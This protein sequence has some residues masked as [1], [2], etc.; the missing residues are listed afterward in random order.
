MKTI[1]IYLSFQFILLVKLLFAQAPLPS[2]QLVANQR[3]H[4]FGEI[5]EANGKVSHTFVFT[6]TSD[7]IAFISRIHSGCG[8]IAAEYTREPIRPKKTGTVT[9]SYNPA[10]HPGFFSKEVVVL[11]NNGTAYN[12]I[13]I[14]GTVISCK[15]PV[16]EKK[17]TKIYPVA[18][19]K[20]STK[21]LIT[22]ASHT[23]IYHVW[24]EDD[25]R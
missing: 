17:E 24:S 8:C 9:V 15:R 23:T 5:Q 4:N 7:S 11:S 19:R 6:N 16:S 21:Q 12:R 20:V 13:W 22:T 18:N 2:R 14:K 25:K 10:Y 3:V 1:I